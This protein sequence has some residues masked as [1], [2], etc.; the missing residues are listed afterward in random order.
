MN[1]NTISKGLAYFIISISFSILCFKT[2]AQD[3]LNIY[4]IKYRYL[5]TADDPATKPTEAQKEQMNDGY[6]NVYFSSLNDKPKYKV[7]RGDFLSELGCWET[8]TKFIIFGGRA[9]KI[10]GAMVSPDEILKKGES[11]Y[12]LPSDFN[13]EYKESPQTLLGKSCHVMVAR[14]KTGEDDHEFWFSL[15]TDMPTVP[16][17]YFGF[18]QDDWYGG[19]LQGMYHN[20]KQKTRFG[21][22]AV[23]F[24]QL[25]VPYDFF[26]LPANMP[27]QEL[28]PPK[29]Y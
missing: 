22:Q 8:M 20:I 5:F 17:Y 21:I 15:N 25:R 28:R 27:V 13:Y 6:L 18:L 7:F 10:V 19:L 29:L 26:E 4:H 3:S 12:L 9:T 2:Y 1:I 14:P 24:S 11:L 23:D 16:W